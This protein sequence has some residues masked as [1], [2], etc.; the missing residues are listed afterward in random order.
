MR[1]IIGL[2]S[3]DIPRDDEFHFLERAKSL[4][5]RW[6]SIRAA[7]AA[8]DSAPQE[9]AQ[10]SVSQAVSTPVL[11]EKRHQKRSIDN[12]ILQFH[13][14]SRMFILSHLRNLQMRTKKKHRKSENGDMI[15][16]TTS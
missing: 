4:E 15:F 13:S 10:V 5:R 7:K 16:S 2:K 14:S 11:D 3:E 6:Q 8:L 1:H 12:G 9:N